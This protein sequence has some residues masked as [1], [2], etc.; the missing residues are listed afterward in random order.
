[1]PGVLL[2]LLLNGPLASPPQ[3]AL[4]QVIA[5]KTP[6]SEVAPPELMEPIAGAVPAWARTAPAWTQRLKCVLP[7]AEALPDSQVLA[8][9]GGETPHRRG[10]LPAFPRSLVPGSFHPLR[11]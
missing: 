2:V 6:V 1:M 3:A 9:P 5:S 10:A 8:E 11:C 7:P 4:A